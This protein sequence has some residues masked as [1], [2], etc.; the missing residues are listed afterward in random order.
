MKNNWFTVEKVWFTNQMRL[1]A[2]ALKLLILQ[3]Q[4]HKSCFKIQIKKFS[5]GK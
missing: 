3:E 1:K 5:T 2:T 4:E